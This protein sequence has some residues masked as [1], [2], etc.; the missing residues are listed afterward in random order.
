MKHT[1]IVALYEDEA[2]DLET[3]EKGEWTSEGKYEMRTDIVKHV[4]SGEHWA[5]HQDRSGSY[6]SDYEY[7]ETT[8]NR[9]WPKEVTVTQ[10]VAEETA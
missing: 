10:W 8:A 7:G 2:P 9:V 3:V 5:V 6:W 4:P 1:D